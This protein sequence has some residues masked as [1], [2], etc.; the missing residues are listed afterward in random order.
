MLLSRKRLYRIKKTKEQSRK[1]RKHRN[2]K[3]YR[4]RKKG[5]S[6]GKRKPLN[7]IE[8]ASMV[9]LLVFLWHMKQLTLMTIILLLC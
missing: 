5:K 6:R 3:K 7:L 9:K 4:R 1:R 8:V 2:K